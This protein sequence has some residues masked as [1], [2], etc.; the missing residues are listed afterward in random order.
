MGSRA[1]FA[2]AVGPGRFA[3][4]AHPMTYTE[5]V[6]RFGGSAAQAIGRKMMTGE[7]VALFEA[8]PTEMRERSS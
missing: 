8:V 7:V 6:A 1:E 2:R 5:Q 3:Y 4:H